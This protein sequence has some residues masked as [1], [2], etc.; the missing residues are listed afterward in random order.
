VWIIPRRE[1]RMSMII[2]G[3]VRIL[4]HGLKILTLEELCDIF[5]V[6]FEGGID[7]CVESIKILL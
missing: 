4:W 1:E 7:V 6:L 2:M 3:R 5:V